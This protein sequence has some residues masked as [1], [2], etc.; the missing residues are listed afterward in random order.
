MTSRY[1][2]RPLRTEAQACA[3]RDEAI[4]EGLLIALD[5][6]RLAAARQQ[7]RATGRRARLVCSEIIDRC[8]GARINL[9]FYLDLMEDA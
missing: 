8:E 5:A 4:V 6:L 2:D 1:L 7:D 9:D 3:Q